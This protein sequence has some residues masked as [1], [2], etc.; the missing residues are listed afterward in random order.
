VLDNNRRDKEKLA[1]FAFPTADSY[2]ITNQLQITPNP[3]V[4][5]ESNPDDTPRSRR[6]YGDGF[7]DNL[8][9]CRQ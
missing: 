4:K 3:N 9:C 5:N 6:L 1:G 8:F 2:K 7:S